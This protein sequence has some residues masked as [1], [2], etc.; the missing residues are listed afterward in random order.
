L[1]KSRKEPYAMRKTPI[2]L[3]AL[4]FLAAQSAWAADAKKPAPAV[5][6]PTYDTFAVQPMKVGDAVGA[7]P[8][9]TLDGKEKDLMSLAAKG[10]PMVVFFTNSTCASCRSEAALLASLKADLKEKMIL[11]GVLTDLSQAGYTSL[12]KSVKEAATFLHDPDFK[13]PPAFGFDFTPAIVVIK[14]GK[15]VDQKG[16]FNPAKDS[17]EIAAL[18]Q[19]NL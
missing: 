12:D 2:V 1:F 6:P 17:K 16:G 5:P 15:L 13:T 7:I 10:V 8:L 18:V 19:K 9:R 11:V 14:G 3:F 4:L